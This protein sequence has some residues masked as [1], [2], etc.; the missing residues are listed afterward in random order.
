MAMTLYYVFDDE[1]YEHEV[2]SVQALKDIGIDAL[3][4]ETDY[5]EQITEYYNGEAYEAWQDQRE[6]NRN[7][8]G[9]VGMKER[10]F[11]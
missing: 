9:Y 1:D 7:P 8:L 11:F 10:D 5:R 4:D 2:N 6:Y 3:E